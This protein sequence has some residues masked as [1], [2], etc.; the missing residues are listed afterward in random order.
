MQGPLRGVRMVPTGGVTPEAARDY[1]AAGAWA[2]GVG[3]ELIK[4][5]DLEALRLRAREYVMAARSN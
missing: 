3:S 5:G 4:S 1:L 2:V